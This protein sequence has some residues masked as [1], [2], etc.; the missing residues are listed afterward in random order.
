MRTAIEFFVLT[1]LEVEDTT[2][3]YTAVF[4]NIASG[5]PV[6]FSSSSPDISLRVPVPS[7]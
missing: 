5:D 3:Y 6:Q 1:F 7:S 4:L 2:D